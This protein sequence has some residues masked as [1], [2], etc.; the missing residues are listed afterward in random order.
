M[1]QMGGQQ[2]AARLW[3]VQFAGQLVEGPAQ[4]FGLA[5]CLRDVD[6]R[7]QCVE[8]HGGMV[9]GKIEAPADEEELAATVVDGNAVAGSCC[10]D[11]LGILRRQRRIG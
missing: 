1:H 8:Q 6:H 11:V 7:W 3:I 4:N 5:R 9:A 2:R 10:Q